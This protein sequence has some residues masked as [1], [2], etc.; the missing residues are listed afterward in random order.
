[1]NFYE[2]IIKLKF[3][4]SHLFPLSVSLV[5]PSLSWFVYLQAS[6]PQRL[7][8]HQAE[9]LHIMGHR[10]VRSIPRQLHHEEPETLLRYLR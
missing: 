2:L 3:L 6:L 5:I 1:M 4:S 9:G 10:P 7:R 8:D